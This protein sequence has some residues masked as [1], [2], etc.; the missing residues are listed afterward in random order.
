[1]IHLIKLAVGIR[2][3][4]HLEGAQRARAE[5]HG[6]LAIRR[7]HTRNKPVR[8]EAAEGSLYWVIQGVIRCRQ[9]ILRFETGLDVEGKSH[10][11]IVLEPDLI[12]VRPTRRAAFQGWRYLDPD[13]APPDL[14]RGMS[15]DPPPEAMLA[16]LRSLGLI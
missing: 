9:R 16:E 5:A 3:I 7:V 13:A 14:P 11:M 8:P 6:D 10:C 12:T 4:T 15:E 1:M 2:D